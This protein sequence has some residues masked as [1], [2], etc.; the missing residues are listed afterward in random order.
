MSYGIAWFG[1][2]RCLRRAFITWKNFRTQ[3]TR[4]HAFL[5]VP[6]RPLNFA[7]SM[8]H[9]PRIFSLF[10]D[11]KS[12]KPLKPLLIPDTT[13]LFYWRVPWG[14]AGSSSDKDNKSDQWIPPGPVL[15]RVLG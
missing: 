5:L 13:G 1:Q 14:A 4:L 15:V 6:S 3:S 12:K 8:S 2:L 7:C 9:F 10:K 11:E